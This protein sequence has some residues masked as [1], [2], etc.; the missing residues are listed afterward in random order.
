MKGKWF[1]SLTESK[2]S[3]GML[4][5]PYNRSMGAQGPGHPRSQ[6][7]YSG[8]VSSQHLF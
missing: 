1:K 2:G 6:R 5:T 3:S 4:G 7:P 8:K